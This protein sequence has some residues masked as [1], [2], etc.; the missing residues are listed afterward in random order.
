[1]VYSLT[2]RKED[3]VYALFNIQEDGK[4]VWLTGCSAWDDG[5]CNA[6]FPGFLQGGIIYAVAAYVLL[7]G[8]S[9]ILDL[10]SGGRKEHMA[11]GSLFVAIAAIL[12]GVLSMAYV[13]YLI[14]VLP[15][16]LGA[17]LMVEGGLYWM[18]AMC[19]KSKW[20]A[21]FVM[22]SLLVAGGG[23]TLVIFAFGFGGLRPLA[24]IFGA[25]LVLSC[26]TE[27]LIGRI[28]KNPKN[29]L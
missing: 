27:L 11:Y 21:P 29:S 19:A 6:F 20:K 14:S 23:A 2:E 5:A 22:L 1:M 28:Y 25:L 8:V 9:G 7:N 24:S 13:R 16:Y 17:L 10:L 3:N 15:I 12:L 18:A 4:M 26:A